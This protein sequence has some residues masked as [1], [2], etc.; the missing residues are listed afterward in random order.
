MNMFHEV[1]CTFLPIS[2]EL[3]GFFKCISLLEGFHAACAVA[4]REQERMPIDP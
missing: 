4:W 3:L 2:K 1:G